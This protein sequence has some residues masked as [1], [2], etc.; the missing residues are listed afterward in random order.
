MNIIGIDATNIRHGGGQ[1]HLIE[2]LRAADPSTCGFS[3]IVVWGSHETLGLLDDRP[4]LLKRT[5]FA[6]S[7]NF[8]RR[9][10]WQRFNLSNAARDEKC[11]ILFI[12]GGS[13]AGDF[14]P[15]VSL[16]QNLLPFELK[17]LFRYGFSVLTFKFLLLRFI[18]IRTFKKS[19]GVIFLSNYAKTCIENVTGSLKG[20]TEIIPHGLSHRFLSVKNPVLSFDNSRRSVIR[21]LYVSSVEPYKHQWNVVE[22]VA[23]ARKFSGLDLQ[24][25]LIGPSHA[26]ALKRLNVAI[27]DNDPNGNW[28]NYIGAVDYEELPSIYAKAHLGVFASSCENMPCILMEMMGSGLPILSSDRGPMPDI[29]GDA[30][31]YFNPE[32]PQSLSEALLDLLASEE[33]MIAFASAA[34]EKAKTFSWQRCAAETFRFVHSVALKNST[35]RAN[36]QCAE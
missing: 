5:T 12:P 1:T 6:H 8:F 28:V 11:T 32:K 18:Q 4:W 20:Y 7:G 21:L 31:L 34:H 15:I 33:R 30:G 16:S 25:D 19:N 36:D 9:T 24:L 35:S 22:G 27:A 26:S 3:R 29:L 2:L 23:K 14:S 13:F 10:L 17:E